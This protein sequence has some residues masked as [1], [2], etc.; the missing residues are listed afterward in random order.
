LILFLPLIFLFHRR[1]Y[2]NDKKVEDVTEEK[3]EPQKSKFEIRSILECY[4]QASN[5]LEERGADDAPTL[6][7]SEFNIDVLNKKLSQPKTITQLTDLFEE[8]RFSSHIITTK[9][10]TQ[11][12]D[13]ASDIIE[14]SDTLIKSTS[15]VR[16][17]KEDEE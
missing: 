3:E 11:A 4:Y 14:R 8:A 10:V 5:K 12:K 6:T 15:D 17:I 7:P 2:V 16:K 9:Q 13:L 1:T